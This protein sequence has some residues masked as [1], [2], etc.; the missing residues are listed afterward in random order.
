MYSYISGIVTEISNDR[1]SLEVNDIAYEIIVGNPFS[2]QI[3]ARYK[4]YLYQHIREDVNLLYG[5]DSR[6]TKQFFLKILAVKGIGP[7]SALTIVTSC[8]LQQLVEAIEKDDVDF[9]KKI[10]GVGAKSAQQIILD[11]KGKLVSQ[12]VPCAEQDDALS[13]ALSALKH[14]GYTS[15]EI[16]TVKKELEKETMS[17]DAYVKLGLKLLLNF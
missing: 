4:I 11:L 5:F 3:D 9:L 10:P 13:A 12:Q 7:K 1:L 6:E 14:L 2:Y 15:T 16:K 8:M 17:A